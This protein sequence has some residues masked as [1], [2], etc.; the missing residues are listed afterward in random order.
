MSK[1]VIK[2]R[3]CSECKRL[4]VPAK[5]SKGRLSTKCKACFGGTFWL[6]AFGKWFADAA[7]RQSQVSMPKDDEDIKRIYQLWAECRSVCGYTVSNGQLHKKYNYQMCHRDPAKGDGFQGQFT[8]GNLMI[9]EDSV[10]KSAKNKQPIDHGYRIYT[11]KKPFGTAA[12]VREWCGGQYNLNKLVDELA[13]KKYQP[14]A[15]TSSIHVDQSFLPEG[16]P[17][18][19]VFNGQLKR[20]EGGSTSPWGH[21]IMRI[22][23]KVHDS[24]VYGIGLGTGRVLTE[25]GKLMDNNKED[26]F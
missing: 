18:A 7:K 12:K 23:Y 1:R 19:L 2:R 10:N 3:K 11:T 9:A 14:K 25:T 8:Y 24:L 15:K 26:D 6:S 16:L 21:T 5:R 13:L 22:S 17:P 4:R 20:F